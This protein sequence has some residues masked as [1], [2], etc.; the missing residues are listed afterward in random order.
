MERPLAGRTAALYGCFIEHG[1]LRSPEA[2]MTNQFD[3]L[4]GVYEDF[5]GLPFLRVLDSGDGN[6]AARV[7]PLRS[8]QQAAKCNVFPSSWSFQAVRRPSPQSGAE[9]HEITTGIPHGDRV[10]AR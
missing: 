7:I 9:M 5:S 2:D 4:S 3:S 1:S 8:T 10:T 6:N